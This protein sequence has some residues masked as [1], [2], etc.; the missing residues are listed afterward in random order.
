MEP[1]NKYKVTQRGYT[2]NEGCTFKRRGF[3]LEVWSVSMEDKQ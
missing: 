3:C 1:K 2:F